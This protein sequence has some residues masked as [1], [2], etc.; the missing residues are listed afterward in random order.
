LKKVENEKVYDETITQYFFFVHDDASYFCNFYDYL[1]D[2][3]KVSM[4]VEK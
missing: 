2:E 3:I 4:R 1:V